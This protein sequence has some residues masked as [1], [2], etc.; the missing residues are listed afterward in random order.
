MRI[1]KDA[2]N[3]IVSVTNGF[4]D[5]FFSV[6]GIGFFM[7][8]GRSVD[9]VFSIADIIITWGMA[10]IVGYGVL[11]I[12]LNI[13]WNIFFGRDFEWKLG[14]LEKLFLRLKPIQVQ[15]KVEE[16]VIEDKEI[17]VKRMKVIMKKRQKG[18]GVTMGFKKFMS[19][20]NANKWT[21]LGVGSIVGVTALGAFGIVDVN[22]ATDLLGNLNNLGAAE[23]I[24][25]SIISTTVIAG[26]AGVGIK[27]VLGAGPESIEQ[28]KIRKETKKALKAEAKESKANG[29]DGIEKTA[30]KL[31]KVGLPKDDA[32]IMA[33]KGAAETAKLNAEAIKAKEDL[34]ET[35]RKAKFAKKMSKLH[36]PQEEIDRLY[37]KK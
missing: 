22:S 24:S 1:F 35:K 16:A 33:K 11:R 7:R 14:I 31:M 5:S 26:T 10:F 29:T 4:S 8:A 19:K 27:A 17:S 12:A 21:I 18:G 34:L 9:Q 23:N 37:N 6:V 3:S 36:L 28:Y 20:L 25:Q 32:Y 30:A 15:N 2:F 13:M